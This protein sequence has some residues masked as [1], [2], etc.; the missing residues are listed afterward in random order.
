MEVTLIPNPN[1][2]PQ[3]AEQKATYA[4][5]VKKGA[6]ERVPM[7]TARENIRLTG[8]MYAIKSEAEAG[9]SAPTAALSLDDMSNDDL[10]I[11]M[12]KAGVTPQKQMKRPE[13]IK[14]IRIKLAEI[15]VVDEETGA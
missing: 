1:F 3:G 4:A 6:M 15:E 2:Q 9:P 10:K 12:L 7:V 13:I 5:I 8:E 14:A 11:M